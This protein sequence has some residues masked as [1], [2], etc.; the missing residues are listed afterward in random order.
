[1]SALKWLRVCAFL[2][3]TSLLLL[4]FV[5]M[6]LKYFFAMPI[7]VRIAGS[8]HGLLFLSFVAALVRVVA[9]RS[10]PARRYLTA[11]VASLVPGGTFVL[12]RTL[13]RELDALRRLA[14]APPTTS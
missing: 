6:P 3:G 9:D 5:A 13:K 8:L 7:A 1:M 10:W 14:P 2:E 11:L 4:F 12:D